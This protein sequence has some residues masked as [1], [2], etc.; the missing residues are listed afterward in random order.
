MIEPQIE[1]FK[2]YQE[3]FDSGLAFYFGFTDCWPVDDVDEDTF[4][5]N[6]SGLVKMVQYISGEE[7]PDPI[8][9]RTKNLTLAAFSVLP[10]FES[11]ERNIALEVTND[12]EKRIGN[13]LIGD[14]ILDQ[15]GLMMWP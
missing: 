8:L 9:I 6:F 1:R 12:V 3:N 14:E 5:E 13:K 10:C 7:K 2:Q 15:F 4:E 11:Q